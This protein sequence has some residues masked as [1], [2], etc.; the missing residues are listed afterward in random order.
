MEANI[1]SKTSIFLAVFCDPMFCITKQCVFLHLTMTLLNHFM[2]K[3]VGTMLIRACHQWTFA[4]VLFQCKLET[5]F[6]C[7]VALNKLWV[8][9]TLTLCLLTVHTQ[10]NS[11]LE[12]RLIVPRSP[13]HFYQ[14]THPFLCTILGNVLLSYISL[15]SQLIQCCTINTAF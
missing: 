1:S 7:S 9:F 11:S 13:R 2:V 12:V 3:S 5:K 6:S 14:V 4:L 8:I 10:H 15:P